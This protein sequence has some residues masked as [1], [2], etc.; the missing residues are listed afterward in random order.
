MHTN[1]LKRVIIYARISDKVQFDGYSLETQV[2]SCRKY[3]A[4]QGWQVVD[5]IQEVG[6]GTEYRNRPKLNKAREMIRRGEADVLLVN[7][8]DRLSRNQ[9]HQG[10]ILDEIWHYGAE[11]DSATEDIENT[12]VGNFMRA[13][14]AFAADIEIEKKRESSARGVAGKVK[15]GYFIGTGTP[16]YGYQWES[17]NE[18]VKNTHYVLHPEHSK[19]VRR[20]FD[21][22]LAGHSL[23]QIEKIL[24][25][26]GV[27][28]PK[29]KK[30]LPTVIQRI[31]K[32]KMYTGQASAYRIKYVK[33]EGGKKRR[34]AHE[35]ETPLPEGTVPALITLEE[36]YAILRRI[37]IN[38]QESPRNN[39][40]PEGSLLRSGFAR[41]GYCK[42]SMSVNPKPGSGTATPTSVYRCGRHHRC[43]GKASIGVVILDQIVWERMRQELA[44][45]SFIKGALE[46]LKA[47]IPQNFDVEAL[48]RSIARVKEE[49]Q[50]L[51][52]NIRG[53]KGYAR[54]ALLAQMKELE[55]ELEKLDK[56]KRGAVPAL[57]KA[58]QQQ[59]DIDNFLA[60]MDKMNGDFDKATYIEKREALRMLVVHVL[61]YKASDPDHERYDIRLSL[62]DIAS[63]LGYMSR[64]LSK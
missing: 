54:D 4:A 6:S 46:L 47:S 24:N 13:A 29:G 11:F 23:R 45:Y 57:E 49:I 51:A 42:S 64:P 55:D 63:Q 20:I 25:S 21:M 18:H 12:P 8:H 58:A 44:D 7:T 22:Y 32:N 56:E 41:C 36:H 26:E 61:V 27:P 17:A 43:S 38:S 35:G 30:W 34:V 3:A 15:H 60:W 39:S 52:P 9:T 1:D 40:D 59:D 62:R 53:L 14:L 37:E 5:E 50:E 19:V 10:V 16:L 2:A 48:D 31:L 33:V 28:S